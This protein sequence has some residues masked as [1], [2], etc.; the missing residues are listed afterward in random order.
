MRTAFFYLPWSGA[1][2]HYDVAERS[3]GLVREEDKRGKGKGGAGGNVV[4][5]SVGS[6]CCKRKKRS[7]V[8]EHHH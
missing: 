6:Q 2:T 4:I 7:G 1:P 5:R 3:A 8:F